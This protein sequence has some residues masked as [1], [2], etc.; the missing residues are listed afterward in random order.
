L[1]YRSAEGGGRKQ[2]KK[3]ILSGDLIMMKKG[4][5]KIKV[6]KDHD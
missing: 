2:R 4:K 1:G 3:G 6:F 5:E